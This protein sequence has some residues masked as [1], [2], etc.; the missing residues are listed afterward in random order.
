MPTIDDL[1]AAIL[2][3]PPAGQVELARRLI[4]HLER[5]RLWPP[6]SRPVPKGTDLVLLFD[7]GSLGNPGPGYGSYL[8][9]RS[10][11]TPFPRRL[12]FGRPMTSN[13][14]EYET[15]IA[16]LEEV[17]QM[18]GDAVRRVCLEV[19]GDS[20]LV[21]RQIKGDWRTHSPRLRA[22]RDRARR[23]LERFR[24]WDIVRVPREEALRWLGH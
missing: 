19:R 12:D 15:L 6:R 11:G 16:G 17:H 22:L 9:T 4:E 2:R 1:L 13:E 10:D 24:A 21:V 5:A 7:G 18:L 20:Q 8:I 23:L 14:A 3:L